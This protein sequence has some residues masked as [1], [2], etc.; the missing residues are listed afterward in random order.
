LADD[1]LYLICKVIMRRKPRIP[2]QELS[3]ME[4]NG[5]VTLPSFARYG[6]RLT[7]RQLRGVL[8]FGALVLTI[9]RSRR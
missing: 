2:D 8:L 6:S 9:F 3:V 1:L 5:Q 4:N 7:K